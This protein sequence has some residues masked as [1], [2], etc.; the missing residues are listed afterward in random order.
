MG[1]GL[2]FKWRPRFPGTQQ[3]CCVPG[4][5]GLHG[6]QTHYLPEQTG[7]TNPDQPFSPFKVDCMAFLTRTTER[8]KTMLRRHSV[9]SGHGGFVMR[10]FSGVGQSVKKKLIKLESI[11]VYL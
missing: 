2:S 9:D 8:Y 3:Y 5:Q 7:Q 6:Q 4:K 11:F 1:G 10:L